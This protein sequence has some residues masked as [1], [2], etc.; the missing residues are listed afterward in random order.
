[1]EFERGEEAELTANVIAESMYAQCDPDENLYVMFDSIV[2]Y[3]RSTTALCKAD[4]TAVK[5]DGRSFMKRS[6]KG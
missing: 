1:M 3:R 6:T 5:Q 2:D 4:Q